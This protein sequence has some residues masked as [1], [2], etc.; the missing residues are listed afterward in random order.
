MDIVKILEELST[1]PG[2]SGHEQT[3]ALKF[4]ELFAP[5]TDEVTID[6]MSNVIA[7]KRGSGPKIML[8]AHMD[9]IALMAVKIED[10]GSIRVGNIGG[11]DPRILPGMQ[12]TVHG[13]EPLFGTIGAK[14]PHLLTPDERKKNY[15]LNELFVDVGLPEKSVRER[16]RV[17]DIITFAAPLTKLLNDRIACKAMDDRAC[18]CILLEAAE[19]LSRLKTD[20]D[21]TFVATTQEEVGSYG[22]IAAAFSIGPDL[23]IGLD[24]CHA[25][26]PD[27]RPDTT[28][29]IDSLCAAMGPFIQPK[30]RKRLMDCA[31]EHHVKI[32]SEVS[33]SY[34]A[35]DCDE[36]QVSRSG[37]PT[38]LLSLPLKYMHTSVEL[39]DISV[40][41]EGGRLIAH[42]LSE[43]REGWE[44]DLWI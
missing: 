8:A 5:F 24:V 29:E 13:R 6:A 38:V 12:V 18:V 15:E 32:Q 19:R 30:L 20:A 35:T 37:V 16:V 42:F 21:I 10:D 25:A 4:R 39:I 44:E 36:M 23:A 2:P 7:R 17:G 27:S 3:V 11:V 22:A 1:I 33:V 41:K 31:A 14:P 43:L 26:L 9:E 28:A 34:T 40:L